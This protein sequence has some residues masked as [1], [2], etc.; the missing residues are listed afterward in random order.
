VKNVLLRGQKYHITRLVFSNGRMNRA[1]THF[2]RTRR[3]SRINMYFS[4]P[5]YML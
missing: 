3:H 2:P 4:T 1:S 5:E